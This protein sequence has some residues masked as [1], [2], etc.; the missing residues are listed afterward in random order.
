MRKVILDGK[1]M[2]NKKAT[3]QHI[4]TKLKMPEYY[5]ENLDALWD[6][7]S[8]Y[9]QAIE[10]CFINTNNVIGKMGDYGKLILQIFQDI[11][12]ENDKITVTMI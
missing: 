10:I 12:K 9:D 1:Q 5:G 3:H 4:K 2:I 11:E 6:I 7:M 8:T